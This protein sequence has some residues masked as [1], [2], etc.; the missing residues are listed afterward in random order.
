MLLCIR[1]GA[2]IQKILI[3]LIEFSGSSMESQ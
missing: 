1:E 2:I 3:E